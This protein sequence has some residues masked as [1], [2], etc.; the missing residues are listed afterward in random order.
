LDTHLP[1]SRLIWIFGSSSD[2]DI[3][4]MFDEL[5][6]RSSELIITRSKHPRAADPHELARLA[7]ERSAEIVIAESVPEALDLAHRRAGRSDVIVVTGSLFVV[8]EARALIALAQGERVESD[9]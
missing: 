5:L 8:A 2:K 6:P 3:A 4:G 1:G 7:S 9:E